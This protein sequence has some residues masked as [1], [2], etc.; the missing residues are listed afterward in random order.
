MKKK[1]FQFW[2]DHS[3][4]ILNTFVATFGLEDAQLDTYWRTTYEE[5]LENW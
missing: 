1:L 5:Q 3:T 2:D 4:G